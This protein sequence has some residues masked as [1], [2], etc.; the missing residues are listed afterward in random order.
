MGNKRKGRAAKRRTAARRDQGTALPDP[1]LQEQRAF[2]DSERSSLSEDSAVEDYLRNVYGADNGPV[3]ASRELLPLG[4]LFPSLRGFDAGPQGLSASSSDGYISESLCVDEESGSEGVTEP[5]FELDSFVLARSPE[6]LS[7][8]ESVAEFA[9]SS[10]QCCNPHVVP[11]ASLRELLGTWELGQRLRFETALVFRGDN[12]RGPCVSCSRDEI[13]AQDD[14]DVTKVLLEVVTRF[15]TNR[16][17][18]A[19][20]LLDSEEQRIRCAVQTVIAFLAAAPPPDERLLFPLASPRKEVGIVRKLASILRCNIQRP[21]S[22]G[23]LY[24]YGSSFRELPRRFAANLAES[25]IRCTWDDVTGID[26][27][28]MLANSALLPAPVGSSEATARRVACSILAAFGDQERQE[29]YTLPSAWWAELLQGAFT[30]SFGIACT[31]KDTTLDVRYTLPCP[32]VYTPSLNA[33]TAHVE[34]TIMQGLADRRVEKRVAALQKGVQQQSLA[35]A[36]KTAAVESFPLPRDSLRDRARSSV[37]T[38]ASKSKGN[39]RLRE[40]FLAHTRELIDWLDDQPR[41]GEKL[42]LQPCR[43]AFNDALCKLGAALHVQCGKI[44]SGSTWVSVFHGPWHAARQRSRV[45]V[46]GLAIRL[47]DGITGKGKKAKSKT[48]TRRAA[49]ASAQMSKAAAAEEQQQRILRA[50]PLNAS[51][52][53][54]Q[55]LVGSLGHRAGAGLGAN[56]DGPVAPVLPTFNHGRRGIGS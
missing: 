49:A 20:C 50:A 5:W 12:F 26:T 10:D 17:P 3:G 8:L 32:T 16:L 9:T 44:K 29:T 54:F 45:E 4:Q 46:E 42:T 27:N 15:T 39:S 56:E 13:R 24:I 18:S 6:N 51:N 43:H 33:V 11:V 21:E 37:E 40:D 34:R 25:I 47:F 31:A 19:I 53:G 55:I 52:R 7:V 48:K 28:V 36:S 23:G 22:G 35:A 30:G 41:A 1:G 14:A 2:I 38:R